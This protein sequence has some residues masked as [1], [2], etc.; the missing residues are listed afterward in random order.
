MRPLLNT[1]FA[2]SLILILPSFYKIPE[3][4]FTIIFSSHEYA[5]VCQLHLTNHEEIKS[6]FL[7][8]PID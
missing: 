8:V 2:Y 7:Q 1:S 6:C 5:Q 4:K 3:L